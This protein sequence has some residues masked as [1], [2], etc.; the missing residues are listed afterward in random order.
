MECS[1]QALKQP[2]CWLWAWGA[3]GGANVLPVSILYDPKG[4][5]VGRLIG[6]AEWASDE[7]IRLVRSVVP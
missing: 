2:R 7:A 5:E 1:L 3:I 6:E 4:Q